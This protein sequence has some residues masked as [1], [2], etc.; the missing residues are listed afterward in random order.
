MSRDHLDNIVTKNPARQPDHPVD[1]TSDDKRRPDAQ[2]ESRLTR[3]EASGLSRPSRECAAGAGDGSNRERRLGRL[4]EPLDRVRTAHTRDDELQVE[5]RDRGDAGRAR[6]R[7]RGGTKQMHCARRRTCKGRRVSQERAETR[8]SRERTRG[9][10]EKCRSRGRRQ[11]ICDRHQEPKTNSASRHDED[12]PGRSPHHPTPVPNP[13]E[14]PCNETNGRDHT[15]RVERTS[16]AR[17][18]TRRAG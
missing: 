11:R 16:R 18:H 3:L 4:D 13:P 7:D 10:I 17:R 6:G 2:P 15:R 8:R 1:M 12:V 9:D 5:S 14:R